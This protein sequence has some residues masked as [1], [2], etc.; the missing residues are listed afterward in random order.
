MKKNIL[1]VLG[2]CLVLP[3]FSQQADVIT[4]ILE[5]EHATYID[6][7]YLIASEMGMECTP[8]EAYTWCDRYEVFGFRESPL[9]PITVSTFSKFMM[10]SYNLKGGI[11][12]SVFR[13]S[14]YAWKELKNSGFWKTGADPS[15]KMSGRDLVRAIG[16]FF[17]MYP[18]ARLKSP[19]RREMETGRIEALLGVQE[20][21]L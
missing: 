11:M 21:S 10:V 4:D 3:V 17:T 5:R 19:E 13:N 15:Q 6:F 1:A 12:W 7:A 16:R 14:R 20:D 2:F 18:D 9:T 8:F